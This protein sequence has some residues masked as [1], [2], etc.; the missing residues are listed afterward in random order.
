[1]SILLNIKGTR[2]NKEVKYQE[3]LHDIVRKGSAHKYNINGTWNIVWVETKVFGKWIKYEIT[4]ITFAQKLIANN[5]L[6]FRIKPIDIEKQL[7][8]DFKT[9]NYCRRFRLFSWLFFHIRQKPIIKLN[10]QS[11]NNIII[12][13]LMILTIIVMLYLAKQEAII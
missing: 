1:M 6:D 10:K 11:K 5:P 4:E 9:S 7:K 8:I 2:K 3:W 12:V 13:W